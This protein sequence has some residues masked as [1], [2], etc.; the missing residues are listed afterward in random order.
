M[1]YYFLYIC[2]NIEELSF[3][4]RMFRCTQYDII[5]AR[6]ILNETERKTWLSFAKM[7]SPNLRTEFKSVWC[8]GN[9]SQSNNWKTTEM[10]LFYVAHTEHQTP[11]KNPT[12]MSQA[13]FKASLLWLHS[14][15]KPQSTHGGLWPQ[16]QQL[17]A[18]QEVRST[19]VDGSIHSSEPW[20]T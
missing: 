2:V 6:R 8:V 3:L 1:Y 9:W 10:L 16:C 14:G 13:L 11:C 15:L 12:R 7:C 18:M 17:V 4:L 19:R 20:P 5:D